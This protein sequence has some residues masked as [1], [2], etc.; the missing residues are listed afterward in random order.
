MQ[1]ERKKRTEN[2]YCLYAAQVCKL[3]LVLKTNL[4]ERIKCQD[5]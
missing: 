1:E 5:T 2:I 3:T 4:L